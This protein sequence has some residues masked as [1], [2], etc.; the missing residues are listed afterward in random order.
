MKESI[1]GYNENYVIST[2]LVKAFD[3]GI[4]IIKATVKSD[5]FL[6]S[7]G[8]DKEAMAHASGMAA[9]LNDVELEAINRAFSLI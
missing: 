4:I 3:T 5:K 8:C 9:E 6:E 7:T 2:E 1:I